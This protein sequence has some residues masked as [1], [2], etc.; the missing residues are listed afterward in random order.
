MTGAHI[1]CVM[2]DS[3]YGLSAGAHKQ[4]VEY[5][6]GYDGLAG[7]GRDPFPRPPQKHW[8]PVVVA[9]EPPPVVVPPTA[10]P[11]IRDEAEMI[12][13]APPGSY[14]LLTG[15]H[16]VSLDRTS[17]QAA[18]TAGVPTWKVAT[19]ASWDAIVRTFP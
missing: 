7:S 3:W 1:H 8:E 17:G 15:G 12:V 10:A 4:V 18:A 6:N 19:V 11:P 2:R 5:D 9:P 14:W 13:V 16:L